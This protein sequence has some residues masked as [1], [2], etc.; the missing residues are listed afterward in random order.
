MHVRAAY[1]IFFV[2][3]MGVHEY[4][5]N[6]LIGL[7]YKQSEL[8]YYLLPKSKVRGDRHHWSNRLKSGSKIQLNHSKLNHVFCAQMQ[9]TRLAS[10]AFF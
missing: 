10:V 6:A 1:A 2:T 4:F 3:I 9:C 7:V 5:Q 8:I